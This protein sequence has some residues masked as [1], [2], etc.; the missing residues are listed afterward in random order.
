MTNEIRETTPRRAALIAGAGYLA[1]FFLAIFANFFVLGGLVES[2]DAAATAGTMIGSSA[3]PVRYP[4]TKSSALSSSGAWPTNTASK[5]SSRSRA[6]P[7]AEPAASS[8]TTCEALSDANAS[9]NQA[10]VFSRA[11]I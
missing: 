4:S 10:P 3:P 11:A 9:A 6:M 5:T 7:A 1:I 8:S 2:G